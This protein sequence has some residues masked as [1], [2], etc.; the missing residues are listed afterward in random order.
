VRVFRELERKK[1]SKYLENGIKKE[2]K[3]RSRTKWVS[4]SQRMQKD[5]MRKKG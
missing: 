2:K 3:E 4:R 5:K 1:K